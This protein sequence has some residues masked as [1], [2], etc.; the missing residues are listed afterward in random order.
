MSQNQNLKERQDKLL[1]KIHEVFGAGLELKARIDKGQR[2]RF[3][4]EYNRIRSLLLAGG[5]LDHDPL[6]R[7][8]LVNVN[9]RQTMA[10]QDLNSKFFG[11]QYALACWLDELFIVY[12]PR[13]WSEEWVGRS[14][15]VSL[16][17]GGQDREWRF[18]TQSRMA[19]GPKGSP[20]AIECFLWAVMLGFRGRPETASPAIDPMLWVENTR[21]RVIATRQT[22][23]PEPPSR[24]PPSDVPPL[25]GADRLRSVFRLAIILIGIA[26]FVLSLAVTYYFR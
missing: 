18:W 15:E 25:K 19:E 3:D 6:Y 4:Q 7:G 22:T 14:L 11:V 2:P 17:G 23:F 16:M 13:W 9:I 21:R 20:E 5:E 26:V 1:K 24:E 10:A 8:E 12:T